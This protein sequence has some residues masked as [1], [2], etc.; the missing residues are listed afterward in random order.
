[1]GEQR[2][3]VRERLERRRERG[4]EKGR[5][6]QR[7]SEG[8]G[9]REGERGKRV[10]YRLEREEEREENILVCKIN[11]IT[12]YLESI[13]PGNYNYKEIKQ[14]LMLKQIIYWITINDIEFT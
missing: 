4:R 13:S 3:R 5:Q 11:N 10:R 14:Y 6:K 9:E 12:I 1:M 2:E 7:E 8:D